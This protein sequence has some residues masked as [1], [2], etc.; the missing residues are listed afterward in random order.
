[1][2]S[3]LESRDALVFNGVAKPDSDLSINHHQ[4]SSIEPVRW[5]C[6]GMMKGGSGPGA[7]CG[8]GGRGAC[9]YCEHAGLSA[10]PTSGVGVESPQVRARLA[11]FTV[12]P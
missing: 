11:E 2:S 7:T 5:S 10:S 6:P 3:C 12:F 4:W 8:L 9:F 1:M